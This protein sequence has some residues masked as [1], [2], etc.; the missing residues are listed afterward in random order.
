MMLRPAL[1]PP[2]RAPSPGALALNEGVGVTPIGAFLSGAGTADYDAKKALTTWF[3]DSAG[4]TPVTASGDKVGKWVDATGHGYDATQ[5][6]PSARLN[7]LLTGTRWTATGDAVDDN[8]LSSFTAAA[9]DLSVFIDVDVPSSLAAV[10]HVFGANDAGPTN[11]LQIGFNTAGNFVAGVGADSIL[12]VKDVVDWRN[13]RFIGALV[14][15][16][17]NSRVKL[18]TSNGTPYDAAKNG[19]PTTSLAA[20]LGASNA[21]GTGSSYFAGGIARIS[22][23]PKALTLSDF[24]LMRTEQVAYNA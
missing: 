2:L 18:F 24:N 17:A 9:G 3:T 10:Q 1:R 15:D 23:A 13:Q 6:T 4:T 14:I 5:G 20:R 16:N 11:R 8:L 21:G 22:V 19:N 12:V 7:A